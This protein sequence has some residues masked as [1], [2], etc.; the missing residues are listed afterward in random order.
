VRAVSLT[1][2]AVSCSVFL[3]VCLPR[4]L[5]LCVSHCVPPSPSLSLS[6]TASLA[7][8][9]SVF[10]TV[11]FPRR[12]PHLP[13]RLLLCVPHCVSP[14]PSLSL[15]RTASLTRLFHRVSPA[16]EEA[17]ASSEASPPPPLQPL[18][19]HLA[20]LA[21]WVL[22]QLLPSGGGGGGGTARGVDVREEVLRRLDAS[23]GVTRESL[24]PELRGAWC[25]AAAPVVRQVRV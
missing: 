7:V 23:L 9:C 4:R 3:T 12:L 5:L 1:S 17:S 19:A 25:D 20:G 18:P 15:S 6:R 11:C 21:G 8:S 22:L 14:S 2:L 10:L 16:A 13:R 24:A